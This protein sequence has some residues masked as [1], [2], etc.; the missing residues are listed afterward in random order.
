MIVVTELTIVKIWVTENMSRISADLMTVYFIITLLL[1][2]S[3]S[4]VHEALAFK[5][6]ASSF[7]DGVTK[8][9]NDAQCDSN[10]CHGHGYDSSCPS[11]HT[12]TF[13]R[14]YAQGYS[15]GWDQQSGSGRSDGQI[16]HGSNGGREDQGSGNS[17]SNSGDSGN[18][19]VRDGTAS[20][21]NWEQLCLSYGNSINIDPS[22]CSHYAHGHQLT[23]DG[24]AFLVKKLFN[25]GKTIAS[26]GSILSFL[27]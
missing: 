9:M 12:S 13:C 17:N 21:L 18:G 7:E 5:L 4:I 8:G 10:Q 1:I 27:G 23:G 19:E 2:S 20:G 11:G 22:D 3:G 16:G 14:G 15:Q 24:K 6:T 26:L 25:A